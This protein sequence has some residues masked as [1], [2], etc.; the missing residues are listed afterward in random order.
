M[1][2]SV[3]MCVSGSVSMECSAVQCI[4]AQRMYVLYSLYIQY[5]NSD[6]IYSLYA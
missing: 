1:Y 5:N 2:A 3:R 4:A 6:V